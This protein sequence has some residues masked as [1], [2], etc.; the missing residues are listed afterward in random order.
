MTAFYNF[1]STFLGIRP[2]MRGL[3]LSGPKFTI[4]QIFP[5]FLPWQR[6]SCPRPV[7][8]VMPGFEYLDGSQ[9]ILRFKSKEL[10]PYYS[11]QVDTGE[12]IDINQ[13]SHSNLIVFRMN[14]WMAVETRLIKINNIKRTGQ[15]DGQ[16]KMNRL[17]RHNRYV[18][19]L[20]SLCSIIETSPA[21]YCRP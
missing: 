6:T 8:R 5:I 13:V 19:C 20:F 16:I 14:Y 2:K 21:V 9:W 18:R 3:K 15:T 10:P 1:F 11:L 17:R 4:T 12:T 7:L